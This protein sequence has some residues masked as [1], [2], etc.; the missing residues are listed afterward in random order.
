MMERQTIRDAVVRYVTY[1]G[2][3]L[4]ENAID[5][6]TETVAATNPLDEEE[7]DIEVS[8]VVNEYLD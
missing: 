6:I 7:L 1:Y 5:T 4:G 8:C 2:H 3:G